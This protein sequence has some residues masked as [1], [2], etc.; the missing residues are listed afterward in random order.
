M[1]ALGNCDDKMLEMTEGPPETSEHL[2][3]VKAT[4]TGE[5]WGDSPA[6]LQSY[7]CATA[8]A[9]LD[10]GRRRTQWKTRNIETSER[11]ECWSCCRCPQIA[12]SN[13]KEFDTKLA[14]ILEVAN[15]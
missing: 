8:S 12:L 10:E 1:I 6:M 9:D 11:T 7:E 15:D 13:G 4:Y 14:L 3:F 5:L 2:R